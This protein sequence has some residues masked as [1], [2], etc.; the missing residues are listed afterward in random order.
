MKTKKRG[1]Q[2]KMEYRNFFKMMGWEH[3]VDV[4]KVVT[5]FDVF[6]AEWSGNN[7]ERKVA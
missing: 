2:M 4:K 5:Q 7:L 6:M 3:I 1:K